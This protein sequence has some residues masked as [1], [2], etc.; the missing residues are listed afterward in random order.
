MENIVNGEYL[1]TECGM[2][3]Q[4]REMLDEHGGTHSYCGTCP[5]DMA[6]RGIS[7]LFRRNKGNP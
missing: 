7:R 1:C 6:V 5:I 2:T 4:T 3:F